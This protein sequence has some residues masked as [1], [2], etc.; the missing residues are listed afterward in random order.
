M[1]C[2]PCAWPGATPH[3]PYF[4]C[5]GNALRAFPTQ[6]KKFVRA[7]SSREY[8][9]NESEG[10]ENQTHSETELVRAGPSCTRLVD[11]KLQ[12]SVVRS[13]YTQYSCHAIIVTGIRKARR[14]ARMR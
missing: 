9:A 12:H 7:A 6:Q 2:G 11:P 8:P 14:K 3:P 5:V 1:W 4:C 10:A 13:L